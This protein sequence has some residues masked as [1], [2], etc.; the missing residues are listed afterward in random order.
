MPSE[1]MPQPL[2]WVGTLNQSHKKIIMDNKELCSD[3]ICFAQSILKKQFPDSN[4]FHDTTLAPI[5]LN[6]KWISNNSFRPSHIPLF[7][8]IIQDLVSIG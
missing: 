4:G 3:I 8:F 6:D 2:P 7:K 1:Q 5:K